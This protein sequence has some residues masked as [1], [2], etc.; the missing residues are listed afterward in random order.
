MNGKEVFTDI[1]LGALIPKE[2]ADKCIKIAE[3]R[4]TRELQKSQAKGIA[5]L[6]VRND[7]MKLGLETIEQGRSVAWIQFNTRS[8]TN[9]TL[10]A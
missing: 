10:Q 7:L 2:L 9:N 6:G 5:S 3:E 4:D 1:K 8:R